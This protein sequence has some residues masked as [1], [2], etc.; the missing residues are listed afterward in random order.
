MLFCVV[1]S[2]RTRVY[3][4]K[5]KYREFFLYIRQH[6]F[7]EVSTGC[8]WRLWRLFLETFRRWLDLALSSLLSLTLLWAEGWTRKFLEVPSWLSWP[9]ML[10]SGPLLELQHYSSQNCQEWGP[11]SSTILGKS[12]RNSVWINRWQVR[13]SDSQLYRKQKHLMCISI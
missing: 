1:S 6:L 2:D 8:P 5:L 4:Y 9:L 7:W 12:N 10:F 11:N 3:R 13:V